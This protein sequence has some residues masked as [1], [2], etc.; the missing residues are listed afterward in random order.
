[1]RHGREPDVQIEHRV[2]GEIEPLM[3]S[4]VPVD[5]DSI[6]DD[7]TFENA[8]RPMAILVEGAL[9]SGKTSLAYHYCQKWAEGNLSM[10]DVVALVYLRHPAVH[11]AGLDLT[12]HQLLLLACASDGEKEIEDIVGKVVQHVDNGLK[13]LLILEGWDEAPACLRNPPNLSCPS[14]NSFLGKLLRSVSSNT[15]IL[16]TSRP[17]SSIDLHNRANVNRVEI[18]GFT[19]ESIHDYF[20]EA[21]S[22]QLSS[23]EVKDE[24]RKLKNHFQKHP[25][26][27]S[28][29]YVP[30]N[31]AIL[32][33]IHLKNNR[34]LPTTHYELLY[35]L[36]LCCIIREVKTR[37]PK[38]TLSTISS[39]DDLPCDLKEQLDSI[40]TLAYEGIM[41]NKVIFTQEELPS[42]LPTPTQEDLPTMGV[43]QRVQWFSISSKTMSYN[44]IHLSIQEFLAA[45]CISK[46]NEGEQV[47]VFQTLLGEPRFS[48]VLR[49]YAGFTKLTKK[50]VQNIITG[51]NFN[52]KESSKLSLLNY[53]RCFF[54]AQISNQLLYQKVIHRLNGELNVCYVTMSPVDCMAVG[55]F[56]AFVL[57]NITEVSVDLS[58]CS[59][60][61]HSLSALVEELSKHAGDSQEGF[62]G[63][64]VLNLNGNKIRNNGIACIATVL[65]TNNTIKRLLIGDTSVTDR[66]MVTL[67][68]ALAANSSVEYL[69]LT[70]LSTQ[71]DSTLKE[72]GEGI[73]KSKLRSLELNILMLLPSSRKLATV[74]RAKVW[75][76]CLKVGGQELI[77]SQEDSQLC[78]LSLNSYYFSPFDINRQKDHVC[79]ALKETASTIN[80]ARTEKGL[81]QKMEFTVILTSN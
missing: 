27:E 56:L 4:K 25:A 2:K 44:F 8:C 21:L 14:D 72:I 57:R 34:T 23:D 28:S 42:I 74:E 79:Q 19:K 78:T 31:A 5:M 13:L 69:R 20:Q 73:R 60:D 81:H 26:I 18:L 3:D 46:M 17:D 1:M 71:P 62:H 10:F 58:Y 52:F 30:L 59:I 9:G 65:R 6:F 47:R 66:G 48:A 38:Q 70:W 49:F 77:Q 35:Q 45:Y 51:R 61:E 12:L 41:Q 16:I 80:F 43:L 75:L 32:T 54:E 39:L 24:W 64:S 76:Q 40:C 67:S 50:G 7:G 53:M 22:T 55:Y 37:Q 68:T 63:V 36:L 15:T 29:C 33:L 11:S